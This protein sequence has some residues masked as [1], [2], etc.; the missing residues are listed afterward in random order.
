MDITFSIKWGGAVFF[1]LFCTVAS[2]CIVG[3]VASICIWTGNLDN[4]SNCMGGVILS[5]VRGVLHLGG[6]G[7]CLHNFL[8]CG[9]A[10]FHCVHG[11]G[12]AGF[13]GE[14][15]LEEGAS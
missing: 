6:Q 13:L 8:L 12:L 2:M 4:N 10:G 5:G 1:F 15:Y 3:T 9:F 14:L 11:G 7:A